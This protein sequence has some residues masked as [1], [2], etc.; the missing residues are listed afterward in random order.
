MIGFVCQNSIWLGQSQS[1][2]NAY[3]NE[4]AYI[5]TFSWSSECGGHNRINNCYKNTVFL[6]CILIKVILAEIILYLKNFFINP[7]DPDTGNLTGYILQQ[8]PKLGV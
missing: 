6:H 2:Q 7:F 3:S 4:A 5:N 1:Q 8:K